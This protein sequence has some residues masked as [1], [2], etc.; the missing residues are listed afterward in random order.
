VTLELIDDVTP[1]ENE[2][3]P[4]LAV[5]PGRF[6]EVDLAVS[7]GAAGL[8]LT[9]SVDV[10][11]LPGG[12][13][14][15]RIEGHGKLI[16][17]PT[18]DEIGSYT[19]D[20]LV[21]NGQQ[22]VRRTVTLQVTPDVETSTRLMGTVFDLDG[23]PLAG[24]PVIVDA[25]QTVTDEN[26]V[27]LIDDGGARSSDGE[28]EE[29]GFASISIL[30]SAVGPQYVDLSLPVESFLS[31]QDDVGIQFGERNDFRRGVFVPVLDLEHGVTVN[32]NEDTLVTNP[33][34]PGTSLMVPAGAI[35]EVD[36]QGNE[37]PYTGK[38]FLTQVPPDR[39]E[40]PLDPKKPT[41]TVVRIDAERPVRFASFASL[42]V[43]NYDGCVSDEDQQ[44]PFAGRIDYVNPF[45]RLLPAKPGPL[46]NGESQI[47]GFINELGEIRV[48]G[49]HIAFPLG[50]S[51][52]YDLKNQDKKPSCPPSPATCPA[53]SE[54]EQ[55]SG[56]FLE[57]HDLV[58]YQSQGVARGIT[59]AY[60]SEW[61]DPRPIVYYLLFVW[62][63]RRQLLLRSRS[64]RR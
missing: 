1:L 20:V 38:L 25:F 49:E 40:Q 37:V 63:A 59:L 44:N 9:F 10:R 47:T 8:P 18:V 2:P 56:N 19:L 46:P 45:G 14:T 27:F 21:H 57:M 5:H 4:E 34:I 39:T 13:P 54:I 53:M 36:G 52:P 50:E 29:S 51:R 15:G 43:P 11:Q 33:N 42:T 48:L 30:A 31:S 3:V 22:T 58:T 7:G 6:L 64:L 24:V 61:A 26:G 55:H 62:R 12:L 23:D 60:T 16:F 41:T 35:V 28:G 32:P 17:E